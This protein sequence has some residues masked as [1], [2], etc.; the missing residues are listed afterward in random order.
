MNININLGKKHFYTMLVLI[1]LLMFSVLVYAFGSS[2]PAV[3]GHSAGEL[4]VDGTSIVN[5]SITGED[6]NISTL[7]GTALSLTAGDLNCTDCI[8]NTEIDASTFALTCI[9]TTTTLSSGNGAQTFDMTISTAG[10]MMVSGSCVDTEGRFVTQSRA[11]ST[12]VWRCSSNDG[13][14]T[15]TTALSGYA[16]SC[17][18]Q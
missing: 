11:V 3:F 14:L 17:R 12:T 1:V 5:E 9:E 13:T 4:I 16:R 8:G 7:N 10:Y 18:P 15:V 2:D 6:I